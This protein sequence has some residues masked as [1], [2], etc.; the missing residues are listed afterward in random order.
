MVTIE[1]KGLLKA[2][3]GD[4]HRSLYWFFFPSSTLASFKSCAAFFESRAA[5]WAGLSSCP[6]QALPDCQ[7][8]FPKVAS[9]GLEEEAAPAAKV[10]PNPEAVAAA[11]VVVSKDLES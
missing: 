11:G 10:R 8:A 4:L 5:F 2:T 3:V 7:A 6:G 1:P 9:E